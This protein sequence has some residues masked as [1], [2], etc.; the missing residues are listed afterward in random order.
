MFIK[1]QFDRT[2]F[3]ICGSR[4]KSNEKHIKTVY[5]LQKIVLVEILLYIITHTQSYKYCKQNI[6]QK[7]R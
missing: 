1:G 5:A 3:A 7:Y 6:S 4:A 2:I